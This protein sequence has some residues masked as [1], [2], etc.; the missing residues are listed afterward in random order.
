MQPTR[1]H[2]RLG[3]AQPRIDRDGDPPAKVD[4]ALAL[5][6]AAADRGAEVLVFPEGF[7]GPLRVDHD[8]DAAEAMRHVA[9]VRGIAV[10]WS[11]VE[12]TDDGRFAT[13][14]YVVDGDGNEVAR[15]PRSHPATGDVHPV[16]NGA[17]MAAGD[18]LAGTRVAGVDVGLLVCSE[19]WLPEVARVLALRGAEVLLAPAGGGF[20]AVARNWQLIA[21]ARAIENHCYVALTQNRVDGEPGTALIAGPEGDIASSPTDD[22]VVGDL[23]LGRVRWLRTRDDSMESPKPF[24]S[25]P[26]LLRA[27]RPHLYGA[28]VEPTAH[29]Y[30]Y[31]AAAGV[32]HGRA[33][34]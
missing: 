3:V 17:P 13:V 25:L 31:D 20:G 2:I 24:R 7:P 12:A 23:D 27:R 19:L 28:L 11:R 21:R 4:Q 29:A 26:G 9:R 14:G 5:A 6:H 1:A 22:V 16:L 15:Y 32:P 10:Y 18:E 33:S 8:Y 34:R 30:D